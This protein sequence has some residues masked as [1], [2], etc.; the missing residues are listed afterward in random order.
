METFLIQECEV[1]KDES[2]FKVPAPR[3]QISLNG[4]WDIGGVVPQYGGVKLDKQVYERVVGV[5][6]E[7]EDKI[8]KLYFEA[9]NFT[10]D[11][12]IDEKYIYT[13]VGGWNPFYVDIS[14]YV[15]AGRSFKLKVDV[16]GML[17]APTIDSK[18]QAQWP[19]GGNLDTNYG[20]IADDVWL[21]AYGKIHIEDVYVKTSYREK[22]IK[23]EYCVK[24]C[25]DK[26]K[27][28]S[29]ETDVIEGDALTEV[30][31]GDDITRVK[32]LVS[33]EYMIYPGESRMIEIEETWENPKLWWVEQPFLYLAESK[34]ITNGEVVD[35]ET[36]RFGFR[37]IWIVGNQ[38]YLNGVRY[39]IWGDYS[40]FGSGW[41]T[42]PTECTPRT[43]RETVRKMKE[44]NIR[45]VR[46]HQH[47]APRY[48]L[49]IA[50]EMGLLIDCESALYA[51]A[52]IIKSN[53]DEYLKNS[54]V[55][56]KNMVKAYRN[57]PSIVIWGVVNEM[58]IGWVNWLAPEEM[59]ELGK[60]VRE[61][62]STRILCY[63]GEQYVGDDTVNY[64][65]PELYNQEPKGDVFGEWRKFI[66]PNKPT[67][68]GEFLHTKSPDPKLQKIMERNRWWIGI[69]TRG[70][71][72][73]GFTDFR[74]AC[75]WFACNDL[76]HPLAINLKN[77]YSPIA[78]FDKNYDRLG[79]AP[80]YEGEL[81]EIQMGTE[82]VRPLILFNDDIED[83]N[84][85]IEVCLRDKNKIYSTG[86]TLFEIE[87]GEHLEFDCEFVVPRTETHKLELVLRTY[88]SGKLRY[89]EIKE[90]IVKAA[91]LEDVSEDDSI[92]FGQPYTLIPWN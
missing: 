78:L 20:G 42:P 85:Q 14:S 87:L 34:I 16:L 54:V 81:P 75:Y 77:A 46:W 11:I 67:G 12:F 19:I 30:I 76:N 64:H 68:S 60:A 66:F 2:V 37:E 89:E 21:R 62:D 27:Y 91:E 9:V 92:Y 40:Q 36:T 48:I 24:N 22:K 17:H 86:T 6:K 59:I 82:M 32:K 57:H 4:I 56:L 70:M 7:W 71:R 5:P 28:I 39:N 83:T 49:E 47:P 63:D 51:R 23:F 53:K 15:T 44:L 13:H 3:D 73:S 29:I 18:G 80:Y 58:G 1:L 38:Y 74:P 65:Y 52:H 45:I 8:I 84:V 50:D 10:A 25:D 69:W 33:K 90:F 31:E 41:Y 88:K 26:V 79:I 72:Y 35:S 61:V 43:F 55:W